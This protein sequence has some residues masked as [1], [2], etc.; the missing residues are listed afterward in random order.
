MESNAAKPGWFSRNWKWLVPLG[1]LAPIMGLFLFVGGIVAVVGGAVRMSD[2]YRIGVE[3]AEESVEVA[4]ALGE[5]IEVGWLVGGNINVNGP[6]GSADLSIPLNG[7]KGSA[8]LYV[9]AEKTAGEWTFSRLEIELE[10]DGRRIDL[11]GR[12]EMVRLGVWT[13]QPYPLFSWRTE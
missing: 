11:L 12:M 4:D 3:R 1:C 7:P 8:T 9:V 6:S 5:P 2:P 13:F 10:F